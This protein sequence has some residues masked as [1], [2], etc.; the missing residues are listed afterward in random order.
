[1]KIRK[2]FY[3][4]LTVVT[5]CVMLLPWNSGSLSR[6]AQAAC[7]VTAENWHE[8]G[9]DSACAGG[10]SNNGGSY[11]PSVAVAPDGTPYVVWSDDS[12]GDLEIY[13]RRWNGSSWEEMGSSSATGG[14]IS[15]N[16]GDSYRPSVAVAPDST[17]YIAWDDES[18]GDSEIYVRRWNGSSWEEVGSGSATGGGISNNSGNSYEASIA[19]APDGTP[20]VAWWDFS[21]GWSEIYVLRWDGSSWVEVGTGSASGGGISNNSGTSAGTSMAVAPDGTPYVVWWDDSSGDREI[22]VRRWNGSIWEEVGAGSA[23]GGGISNNSGDSWYSSVAIAPNG[24]PYVAWRDNSGGDNEIYVRRWSGSI[25]EEVGAGSASDGGISN[26]SGSSTYP[27]VAIALDGTPY[28]TWYDNSGG[29]YEIYVRHWNGSSWVEVGAGSASGGGISENSDWSGYPSV[30]IAPDDTPYIAWS[31]DVWSNGYYEIYVRR[32]EGEQLDS[33]FRP[34]PDGYQFSNFNYY[35]ANWEQFKAAFPDSDVEFYGFPRPLASLFFNTTYRTIGEGG[36]CY[37]FSASSLVRFTNHSETVEDDLL[38]PEHDA[39]PHVHDMPEVASGDVGPGQSDVKDYIHLYQARQKNFNHIAWLRAHKSDTPLNSYQAIKAAL[40][41]FQNTPVIVGI[42]NVGGKGAHAM[43]PYRVEET[44]NTAKIYVYDNESHDDVNR[45]IT[46]ALTTGAWSY[47]YESGSTWGDSTGNKGL[48]AL[49][50][51]LSFPSKLPSGGNILL[52]LAFGG[53]GGDLLISDSLGRGLGYRNGQMVSEIPDA[54]YMPVMGFDPDNPEPLEQY[55][56]PPGDY[57]IDAQGVTT[58]VYTITAFTGDVGL[59][60]GGLTTNIS[61]TN[62]ISV[63][64]GLTVTQFQPVE[65]VQNYCFTHAAEFTSTQSGRT[66]E[67]YTSTSAGDVASFE[68]VSDS[69]E[70]RYHNLGQPTTYTLCV[71]NMG[72]GAAV[73][74]SGSLGSGETFTWTEQKVYL[75]IILKSY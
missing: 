19:I 10:I 4:V 63:T 66:F 16:S 8:V 64:P 26:N 60:L 29:D 17:L 37:G 1:M 30:A 27:S 65:E 68:V 40:A 46:I 11:E 72:A 59:S 20:Y 67:L 5:L 28:V 18:G 54:V 23:S 33:G 21:S 12:S 34:D 45:A 61:Q 50:L 24:I 69:T 73:C 52:S 31:D 47:T 49:P 42:F 74:G 3:R 75:P 22:Y 2:L 62:V 39:L 6:V 53:D 70:F 15:N 48:F 13:L 56:L 7:P 44:G 51:S 9:A 41:D 36:N 35:G 25:W 32:W 58:G 57:R 71:Q 38:T 14:G 55:S 43:V